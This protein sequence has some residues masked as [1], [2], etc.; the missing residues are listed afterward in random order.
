MKK[1][2]A[3]LSVLVVIAGII[4]YVIFQK[5]Y[6][7]L[8]EKYK[9]DTSELIINDV[10]DEYIEK[11]YDFDNLTFLYILHSEITSANINKILQLPDLKNLSF[12][13]SNVDFLGAESDCPEKLDLCL[14]KVKNLKE[15]ADCNSLT[16]L[17][18]S[19]V[20]IDDKLIITDNTR[21]H[22]KYSLKDSSDF[23]FF[24]NLETLK[25]Y[26]TKI[27]DISGFIKMDLLKTLTV[28]KG[29]I[30]GENMKAL[31][32]KGITVIEETSEE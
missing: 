19:S 13:Y 9:K 21:F 1:F 30:S 3:V 14:T 24:D 31:E 22:E 7:V 5:Q 6:V 29:Y 2:I 27:E 11:M 25:I 28:S 15:L 12:M 10:T 20:T 17:C 18:I 16:E 26:G 32:N 8:D 23:A 4:S